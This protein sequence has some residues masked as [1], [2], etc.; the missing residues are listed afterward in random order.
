MLRKMKNLRNLAIIDPSGPVG[1]GGGCVIRGLRRD[2]EDACPLLEHVRLSGMNALLSLQRLKVER[3]GVMVEWDTGDLDPSSS[4][5]IR[6]LDLCSHAGL[7][8]PVPRK[9][10]VVWN[11]P[12]SEDETDEAW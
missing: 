1:D 11:P 6:Q 2:G 9:I 4:P 7:G 3:P 10:K 5:I 12:T 8:K